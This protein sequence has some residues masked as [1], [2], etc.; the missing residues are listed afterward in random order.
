MLQPLV[1]TG[2]KVLAESEIL[3]TSRLR[4]EPAQITVCKISS[5]DQVDCQRSLRG[6]AAFAAN[7]I[8]TLEFDFVY[9]V[10]PH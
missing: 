5:H 9:F 8:T 7:G 2:S 6:E 3:L 4:A 1:E 10:W